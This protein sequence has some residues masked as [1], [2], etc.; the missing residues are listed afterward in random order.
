MLK[1][2]KNQ[3]FQALMKV[4]TRRRICLTGS[5]FQNN[6]SEYFRMISYV[7]PGLLGTSEIIFQK[8]FAEPIEAGMASDARQNVKEYAD[9]LIVKLSTKLQPYVHRRDATVL[10]DDLP[11]LQQVCLHIKPTIVQRVLY[12][13]YRK[14]KKKDDAYNN[15]LKQYSTLRP[16]HNHPATLLV[17]PD[18]QGDLKSSRTRQMLLPSE[19]AAFI[20]NQSTSKARSDKELPTGRDKDEEVE[21]TTR[22]EKDSIL[23]HTNQTGRTSPDHD[24][25][26]D[27]LSDSEPEVI[28]ELSIDEKKW[29][30]KAVDKLGIEAL[31]DA[32][33]SNKFV[34]LLHLLSHATALGEKT[35]LFTQCLK[36]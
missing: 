7:R 5:P 28:H 11:S 10:L 21:M 34:L 23:D 20:D 13:A 15:F 8:D 1:N 29:W 25:I 16:I 14:V 27:L 18:V 3:V 32:G 30:N 4:K 12:A 36:V 9:E 22:E 17:R 19:V 24:D 6:L 26:I 33:S 31:S 35:V 2:K